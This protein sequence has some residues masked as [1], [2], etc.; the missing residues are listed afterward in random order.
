[1][2]EKNKNDVYCSQPANKS[3]SWILK[4]WRTNKGESSSEDPQR[5]DS[6]QIHNRESFH[7]HRAGTWAI[8]DDESENWSKDVETFYRNGDAPFC[9]SAVFTRSIELDKKFWGTLLGYRC[10][11]YLTATVIS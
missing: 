6:N 10:N 4:K 11:G 1:M 3:S 8:P 7:L 2:S 9:Y 5:N